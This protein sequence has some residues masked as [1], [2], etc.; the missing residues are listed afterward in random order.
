MNNVNNNIVYPDGYEADSA[1]S[2]P[3]ILE[4]IA[5]NEACHTPYRYLTEQGYIG[6]SCQVHSLREAECL[7]IWVKEECPGTNGKVGLI[8]RGSS[9]TMALEAAAEVPVNTVLL[10]DG[11]MDADVTPVKK[12]QEK[13]VSVLLWTGDFS[14]YREAAVKTYIAYQNLYASKPCH[15][16]MKRG[17]EVTAACQLVMGKEDP[18]NVIDLGMWLNWFDNWVKESKDDLK[19]TSLPLHLWQSG[20]GGWF[21]AAACPLVNNSKTLFLSK[22]YKNVPAKPAEQQILPIGNAPVIFD[23]GRHSFVV[24]MAGPMCVNLSAVNTEKTA[25]VEVRFYDVSP[26]GLQRNLIASGKAEKAYKLDQENSWYDTRGALSWPAFLDEEQTGAIRKYHIFMGFVHCNV[27]SGHHLM[28]EIQVQG[29]ADDCG[30]VVGGEQASSY[31]YPMAPG[32]CFTHTTQIPS[33]F[34]WSEK[35][36]VMMECSSLHMLSCDWGSGTTYV[37]DVPYVV[38]DVA[39]YRPDQKKLVGRSYIPKGEGPFPTVIFL[40]GIH[41]VRGVFREYQDYLARKGIASFAFD[42]CGGSTYSDSDGDTREMSLSSMHL[43]TDTIFEMVKKQKDVDTDQIFLTGH[44]QGGL[45][46]LSYAPSHEKDIKALILLAPGISLQDMVHT[47]FPDKSKIPDE[48]T[49]MMPLGRRWYEDIYDT[50]FYQLA[51]GYTKDVLL[52]HGDADQAVP[53]S[54]SRKL[55]DYYKSVVYYEVPDGDHEYVDD[56][57]SC[58][59]TWMYEFLA[60]HIK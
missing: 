18:E 38:Q 59:K 41:S 2:Y 5:G 15:S 34:M 58:L 43:D 44:S 51:S 40:H 30:L 47:L 31:M 19:Y 55:K 12:L 8:A 22:D 11:G 1:S 42:F 17:Q 20:K 3:V 21:N 26:N 7:I 13:G 39:A 33:P 53:V 25:C 32:S 29:A 49:L 50:D 36:Q 60:K 37:E 10:C 6:I 4:L 52:T 9:C 48:H 24:G 56:D 14:K 57:M 28:L 35:N 45:V 27:D 46:A 54:V 23:N 16:Q